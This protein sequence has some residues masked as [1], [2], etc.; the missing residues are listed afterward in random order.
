MKKGGFQILGHFWSAIFGFILF[1]QVFD[2][3]RV[4]KTLFFNN[5][6]LVPEK[7]FIVFFMVRGGGHPVFPTYFIY[8]FVKPWGK[9][10]FLKVVFSVTS[11]VKKTL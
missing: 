11:E 7:K 4:K 8:D 5:N 6:G 9:R 2:I 10:C 3:S 1:L